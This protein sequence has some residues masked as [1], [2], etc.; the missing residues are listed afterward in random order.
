MV[1]MIMILGFASFLAANIAQVFLLAMDT[2]QIFADEPKKCFLG[3][4]HNL[5]FENAGDASFC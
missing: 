3:I 2:S 1:T 5:D 4:F